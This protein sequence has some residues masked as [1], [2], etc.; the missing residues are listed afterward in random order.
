MLAR[1]A[2]LMLG[3]CGCGPRGRHFYVVALRRIG[4][5]ACVCAGSPFGR[6]VF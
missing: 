3:S 4:F 1:N 2:R 5:C 6:A